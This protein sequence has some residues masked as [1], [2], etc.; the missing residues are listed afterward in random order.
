[1]TEFMLRDAG[2]AHGLGH[3]VLR[4]FN[5][6]GAEPLGRSDAAMTFAGVARAPAGELDLEIASGH[7]SRSRSRR[8]P[9]S[10]SCWNRDLL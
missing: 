4:Y 9:S 7:A 8:A 10:G 3:V 6:A 1:M 2:A 5:V